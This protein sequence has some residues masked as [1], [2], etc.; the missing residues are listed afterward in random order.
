[1][2]CKQQ[3]KLHAAVD[4]TDKVLFQTLLLN[5]NLAHGREFVLQKLLLLKSYDK[6]RKKTTNNIRYHVAIRYVHC[7][8]KSMRTKP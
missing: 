4:C 2:S 5:S 6:L 7:I 8:T 1:M 3:A